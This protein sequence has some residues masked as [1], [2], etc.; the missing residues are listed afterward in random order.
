MTP[1]LSKMFFFILASTS[2]SYMIFLDL[3]VFFWIDKK[4][5]EPNQKLEYSILKRILV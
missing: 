1:Y 5:K 4:K 3:Y 2:K